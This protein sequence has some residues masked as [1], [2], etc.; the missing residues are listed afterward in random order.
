MDMSSSC[1][2]ILIETSSSQRI[3]DNSPYSRGTKRR[4]ITGTDAVDQE[5]SQKMSPLRRGI[6][7]HGRRRS[8]CKECGG[9]GICEHGRQRSK[10]KECGGA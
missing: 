10:C 2:H 7:E 9:S 3:D 6:C 8:R 4:K 1:L 5:M